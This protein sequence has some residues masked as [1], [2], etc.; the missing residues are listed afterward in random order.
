MHKT[1]VLLIHHSKRYKIPKKMFPQKVC[2]DHR[3]ESH[4]DNPKILTQGIVR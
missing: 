4:C 2:E 3:H 1:S